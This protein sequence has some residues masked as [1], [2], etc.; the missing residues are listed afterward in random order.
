MLKLKMLELSSK[1]TS[2]DRD[3]MVVPWQ[4]W[5]CF[6]YIT[7]IDLI[8][9]QAANSQGKGELQNLTHHTTKSLVHNTMPSK[10]PSVWQNSSQLKLQP[11][12]W[13][14]NAHGIKQG[15]MKEMVVQ[16]IDQFG[17][18]TCQPISTS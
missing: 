13:I 6:S 17:S 1:F 8:Q 7:S 11:I 4:P 18:Y 2:M 12:L 16:L 3:Q 9:H 10:L 14:Y 15:I 5:N